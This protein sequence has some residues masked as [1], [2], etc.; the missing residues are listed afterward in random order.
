MSTTPSHGPAEPPEEPTETD[1]PKIVS[2]RY[3]NGSFSLREEDNALAWIT[4]ARPDD[5][6][7]EVEP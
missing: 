7:V 4:T 3:A 5:L 6:L 1:R 2:H